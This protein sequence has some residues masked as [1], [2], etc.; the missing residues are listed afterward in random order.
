MAASTRTVPS[1]TCSG[2]VSY[3][4][5]TSHLTKTYDDHGISDSSNDVKFLF[6]D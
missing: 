6:E 3:F 2:A 4:N 5:V 1:N